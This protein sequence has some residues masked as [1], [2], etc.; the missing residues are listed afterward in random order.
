[1]STVHLV[2][3]FLIAIIRDPHV[4]ALVPAY[5]FGFF[6]GIIVWLD[7]QGHMS[8]TPKGSAI[9]LRTLIISAVGAYLVALAAYPELPRLHHPIERKIVGSI[10]GRYTVI[11][12]VSLCAGIL[13]VF[14][15]SLIEGWIA[16]FRD[17]R[18][19]YAKWRTIKIASD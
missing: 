10:G 2:V 18:E 13:G 12:A 7:G 19:M 17:A 11:A 5:G 8:W 4:V 1:M 15:S 6:V 14:T 16:G 3:S 9:I